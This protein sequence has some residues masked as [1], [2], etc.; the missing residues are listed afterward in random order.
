[1]CSHGADSN[2]YLQYTIF[3]I[4]KKITLNYPKS[5]A[6]GFQ[7]TEERVLNRRGKRATSV[8]A[9]EVLLYKIISNAS[10]KKKKILTMAKAM[11]L[12][13]LCISIQIHIHLMISDFF[14]SMLS[15]M[16]WIVFVRKLTGFINLTLCIQK[17]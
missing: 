12:T 9:T 4:K 17:A 2:E 7:G 14:L 3:N 15:K 5:A 11:L 13:S 6:M 16:R 1:M 10:I 8:R